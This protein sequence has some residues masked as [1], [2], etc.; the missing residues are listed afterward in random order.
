MFEYETLRMIWWVLISV[1]LI[2]FVITDGFDMGVGTL[3]PFITK[4]DEE[5]RIMLRTIAPHWE[6]N[7]VWL[8]T[9]AAA[10]FA[11]WPSVY[12]T[13]FSGFYVAM[14]LTLFALFFRPVG[15]EYRNKIEDPRWRYSWDW[16]IFAG[17]T[18]PPIVF[19][20]AFA[21]LLEGVPYVLNEFLQSQ[22][23]GGFLD[24]FNPFSLLVGVFSLVLFV[25]QGST[26]L[27]MKTEGDL[28]ARA[29]RITMVLGPVA[30]ILFAIAGLWV[31]YGLNGYVLTSIGDLSGPSNPFLKTVELQAGGWLLNYEKYPVTMLAP[32]LGLLFPL[33]AA[34]ASKYNRCGWAFFTTSLMQVA[35]LST[36][37]VSTFPFI[38]SSSIDPNISFTVWD[39]TSSELTLNIM[40]ITAAIFLPIILL[41]T[42]W[43]YFKM[44]GRIG[45][46][47]MAKSQQSSY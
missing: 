35:V 31:A 14:M 20:V 2:G 15:L 37:A 40:S 34:L 9:G 1:L 6:G 33:L 46:E 39:A 7:Q 24:L 30:T 18:I 45:K 26:W 42:S 5:R 27:Q 10:I 28:R 23:K 36:F 3:L 4:K 13:A 29:R 38:L 12:A 21:N 11:A 8:V 25:L 22:Y 32:L 16:A 44:F 47:F 17:S 43:G 19:G 41:Y